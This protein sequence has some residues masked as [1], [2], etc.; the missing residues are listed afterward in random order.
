MKRNAVWWGWACARARSASHR[1]ATPESAGAA[2]MALVGAGVVTCP[3]FPRRRTTSATAGLSADTRFDHCHLDRDIVDRACDQV[4]IGQ[5]ETPVP[6]DRLHSYLRPPRLRPHHPPHA[7]LSRPTRVQPH[8]WML[9]RHDQ[10][11]DHRPAV[12]TIGTSATGS[13]KSPPDR[14]DRCPRAGCSPPARMWSASRPSDH[15]TAP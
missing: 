15:R 13:S 9:I 5:L 7:P 1:V 14:S 12:P 3:S 6:V 8:I 4:P 10:I 2:V 11:R